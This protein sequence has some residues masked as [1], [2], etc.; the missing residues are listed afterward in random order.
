[1][2]SSPPGFSVHGISQ[3]RILE[4]VAIFFSRGSSWPRNQ[5]HVF[6]IAGR[7]FTDESLGKPLPLP[8]LNLECVLH[9]G[10]GLIC[11]CVCVFKLIYPQ[12][13]KQ[14]LECSWPSLNICRTDPSTQP[15]TPTFVQAAPRGRVALFWAPGWTGGCRAPQV[16]F[17]L[18]VSG[19]RGGQSC[20][21]G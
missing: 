6:C 14:C 12:S 18:L 10:K 21:E 1:M 20:D 15:F 5:I 3:A 17:A 2:D 7:C 13:L 16:G 11:L 4:W 8:T 9:K 19:E